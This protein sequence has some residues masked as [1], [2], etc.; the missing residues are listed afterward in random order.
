MSRNA[1]ILEHLA[2]FLPDSFHFRGGFLGEK[3]K[4]ILLN[5]TG[6]YFADRFR[7]SAD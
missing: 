6:Q 5:C 2:R 4:R 3:Q 1:G 7:D